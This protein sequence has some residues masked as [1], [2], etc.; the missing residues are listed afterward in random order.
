MAKVTVKL[1]GVYRVDTGT[2]QVELE[3]GNLKDVFTQLHEKLGGAQ[4]DSGLQFKDAAVYVGG[5]PCKK[6][7]R[8]LRDGDEI[9]LLSPA[10]GG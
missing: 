4:T 2:P 9:W 6:K 5:E 3:C 8:T 7:S 10:S 1:F